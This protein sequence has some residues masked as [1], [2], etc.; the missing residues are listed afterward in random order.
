MKHIYR[1]VIIDEQQ[2]FFKTVVHYA[3]KCELYFTIP[4]L[5][6]TKQ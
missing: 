5:Y 1:T 2:T 6:S 4:Q 3:K